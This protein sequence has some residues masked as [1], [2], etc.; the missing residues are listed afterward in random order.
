MLRLAIRTNI[1]N[2]EYTFTTDMRNRYYVFCG[3]R[4]FNR[5]EG[6]LCEGECGACTVFLDGKA[7]M[8]VSSRTARRWAKIVTVEGLAKG[9]PARLKTSRE[10]APGAGGFCERWCNP[11]CYCTPGFIMSAVK[12]LEERPHPAGKRSPNHIRTC[13]DAPVII[14]LSRQ[15]RMLPIIRS[16]T[17]F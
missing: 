4:R 14:R 11:V 16:R 17:R 3:R 8:A 10:A 6:R 12:L 13:A 1:N 7:V 9:V 5:H 15:L 2:Q